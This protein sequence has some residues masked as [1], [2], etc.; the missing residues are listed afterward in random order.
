MGSPKITKRASRVVVSMIIGLVIGVSC[1]PAT[2]TSLPP[3]ALPT[4]IPTKEILTPTSLITITPLKPTEIPESKDLEILVPGGNEA[5]IDGVLS[6]EEWDPAYQTEL[7]GGGEL[8]LMHEGG[9]LYLGI[10]AKP[11][12]VTSICLDQGD[13]VSILHSSAAIGTATYQQ[14]D[15]AW[16]MIRGFEW[17]CREITDSPQAQE[18]R[19]EH[20][21]QNNWLASN[22][23]MGAA[24]DVE[25]KIGMPDGLLRLAITSIGAPD[26]EDIAWWPVD[27]ADDCRT[28]R[29]IQ[30]SLPDQAQFTVENWMT[31]TASTN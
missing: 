16:E 19:S 17:C 22:G 27:M 8:L 31:L 24:E 7:V 12:P 3:T 20:L 25:F 6:P 14:G 4:L 26:Y 10:R 29:M 2:I 21:Q 9:Y 5:T 11:E 30:G 15:E 23:R 18:L 13:R 1:A 28:P